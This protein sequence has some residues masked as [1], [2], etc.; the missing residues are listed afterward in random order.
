MVLLKACRLGR[1][2]RFSTL[3]ALAGLCA[4]SF[5]IGCN[6][7]KTTGA[8]QPTPAAA[9]SPAPQASKP[10]APL[11]PAVEEYAKV[12]NP[13]ELGLDIEIQATFERMQWDGAGIIEG[14]VAALTVGGKKLELQTN[15][16]VKDSKDRCWIV[17]T[18]YGRIRISAAPNGLVFW[19]TP[20]QRTSIKELY[21]S[22]K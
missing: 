6:G 9:A 15:E 19:L 12:Q 10:A 13:S 2:R 21:N 22:G 20:S 1:I 3:C 18:S 4:L 17:T 16:I 14:K 11:P 8:S 7:S 5:A